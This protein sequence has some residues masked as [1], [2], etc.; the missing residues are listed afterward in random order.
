MKILSAKNVLTLIGGIALFQG[1]GFFLGADA[2]T[3]GA[4]A[5]LNQGDALRV[6]TL[7]HEAATSYTTNN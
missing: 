3:K 7:I 2:I 5:N 1:I 6:G 4:F